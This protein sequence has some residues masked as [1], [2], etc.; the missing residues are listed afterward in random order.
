MVSV[1]LHQLRKSFAR[2]GTVVNGID[3]TIDDGEFFTLLGPSGCGKST[4]LRMIA[5][6]EEPD[7]GTIHF[8]DRDVTYAPAN[9]RD[10]GLVFQNYA[11]FPHMSVSRNVGFG[12][13]V[14]G[15]QKA[16][17]AR[18]ISDVLQQVGLSAQANARVDEL[19]GG[20][21]QRVALARALVFR[22]QLLLL[23]EPMSNLD[24]KLRLEMRSALRDLH[25]ETGIT[26]VYVTHDQAEALAMSTR[27]A[28]MNTAV[29]HQVGTPDEVYSRPLT[30]FV[31]GFLGRNNLLR[32]TVRRSDG[33]RAE[34]TL[35]DGSTLA[36]RTGSAAPGVD[37]AVGSD[38]IATIRAENVR[39]A[40]AADDANAVS[41]TVAD[42][43]FI[44]HSLSCE[45]DTAVGRIKVDLTGSHMRPTRGD[46]LRVVLPEDAA[47]C[48]PADS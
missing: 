14:R 32:A 3:L 23:D 5:G 17:A 24:A 10:V 4:T 31:A 40:G 46:A 7:S 27:I 8:D 21:Q 33:G 35:S 44:G 12:L 1:S 16:E 28:V 47:Y 43:D 39:L 22:P 25:A 42:V 26:S 11:L 38:V 9:K 45:L 15:V 29:V 6:F 36:V 19:S 34:L 30:A 2:S 37:F 48:V 13:D 20:Q 41:G 18:R